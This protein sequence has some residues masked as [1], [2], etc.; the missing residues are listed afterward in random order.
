MTDWHLTRLLHSTEQ[1]TFFCSWYALTDPYAS[2]VVS[3]EDM[4][5]GERVIGMVLS[6]GKAHAVV[7]TPALAFDNV[8]HQQSIYTAIRFLMYFSWQLVQTHPQ[9]QREAKSRVSLEPCQP[10]LTE[11]SHPS[12][13]CPGNPKIRQIRGPTICAPWLQGANRDSRYV[14]VQP[15]TTHNTTYVS[16]KTKSWHLS[17][18]YIYI[19]YIAL[20]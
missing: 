20:L 9:T 15:A 8:K 6:F 4:L 14:Q 3:K 1:S 16:T 18:I 10:K 17:T 2:D 19:Y 12:V 11:I 7:D 13:T 5:L